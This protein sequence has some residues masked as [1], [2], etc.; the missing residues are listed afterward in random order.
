MRH[1]RRPSR[2]ARPYS[3]PP[4]RRYC[5]RVQQVL[6]EIGETGG[7]RR[8]CSAEAAADSGERANLFGGSAA[9]L[10]LP[11]LIEL[12]DLQ[13]ATLQ[14]SLSASI[15][16]SLSQIVGERARQANVREDLEEAQAGFAGVDRP[17]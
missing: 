11:A 7:R 9:G 12:S 10:D 15:F 4:H 2:M 3:G 13:P 1:L 5:R 8:R 6:H 16:E 17:A 14:F